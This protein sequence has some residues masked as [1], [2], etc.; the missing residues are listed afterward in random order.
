MSQDQDIALEEQFAQ[1]R[2]SK[3][4]FLRL[5]AYL[6]PYK[7]QFVLN[8]AFTTF[9]T[10]SSLLGPKFIQVGIDRFL[11][12]F[13]SAEAALSGILMVSVIYLVNLFAGWFLSVAQVKT[14]IAIGQGAMNDLR[15]SVFA[16]IQSLSLN[17]FDRTRQ[18]RIISRA[19]SDINSLD[20]VL[21]WGANQL[22]SS[23]LTLLGACAILLQ[24]EW[25]LCLAVS[26]AFVPCSTIRPP[27]ITR[28]WSACCTVEYRWAMMNVVRPTLNRHIAS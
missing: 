26:S 15:K 7:R 5:M 6:R 4:T 14:S 16:H 21:T 17:F 11:T 22:L 12:D 20:Q 18:G 19:D 24:Y 2:M 1:K 3:Q 23:G 9:A 25:R 28:I 27:R 8:L 13:T 10:A